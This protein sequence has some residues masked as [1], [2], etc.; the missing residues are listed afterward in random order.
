MPRCRQMICLFKTGLL[1][2]RLGSSVVVFF[3]KYFIYLVFS[4]ICIILIY[5]TFFYDSKAPNFRSSLKLINLE[6]KD[7]ANNTYDFN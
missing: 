5:V 2:Y 4:V 1:N 7:K 6:W 3:K